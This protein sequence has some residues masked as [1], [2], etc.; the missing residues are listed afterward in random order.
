MK[1]FLGEYFVYHNILRSKYQFNIFFLCF[2]LTFLLFTV[3][4]AKANIEIDPL[5]H[6]WIDDSPTSVSVSGNTGLVGLPFY[7]TVY[8]FEQ[9]ELN[10]WNFTTVL[11]AFQLDESI[12]N[13]RGEFGASVSISNNHIIIGAPFEN[14]AYIFVRDSNNIWIEQDKL[15][16]TDIPLSR[17]GTSVSISGNTALIGTSSEATYVFSRNSDGNWIQETILS[18]SDGTPGDNFGLQVSL[19]GNTALI[20]ANR[21]TGNDTKS[22]AAYVFIRD[23]N[24]DWIQQAKLIGI[25]SEAYDN[26]GHSVSLSDNDVI[27]GATNAHDDEYINIGASY[28]FTRDSNGNWQQQAK[29]FANDP[30]HSEQFGH[31]VS[32]SEDIAIIGDVEAAGRAIGSV[33]VFTRDINDNWIKQGRISTPLPTDYDSLGTKLNF[34]FSVSISNSDN[35]AFAGLNH[36]ATDEN[37][38]AAY[39]INFTRTDKDSDGIYDNFDNCPSLSNSS[40]INNDDD[41]QGDACDNDDDNDGTPDL[42]DI[43]PLND[44]ESVDSDNDG[45]GNNADGDNDNDGIPN[46]IETFYVLDPLNY[47]DALQDLDNDGFS[48]LDEYHAGTNLLDPNDS[49]DTVQHLHYKILANDAQSDYRFGNNIIIEGDR[50]FIAATGGNQSVSY[51]MSGA[52]YS[53]HVSGAVYIYERDPDENWSFQAK[54]TPDDSTNSDA[55]GSSIAVSGNILLI[56]ASGGDGLNPY[57]GAAYAFVRNDDGS[58]T[59]EAKLIAG[60]GNSNDNFGISISLSGNTALIGA[61]RP[62][63]VYVYSRDNNGNWTQQEKLMPN[64]TQNGEGFG[65]SIS[66]S[67]DTALIG[68]YSSSGNQPNS[69]AA[70]IFNLDVNGSW[71]QQ[72]KLIA[73]DGVSNDG[74]GYSVSL[75]GET[76]IIGASSAQGNR[77]NSGAAYIYTRNTAESWQELSKLYPIDGE[78][79]DDFGADVSLFGNLALV[80]APQDEMGTTYVYSNDVNGNW[81][82]QGKL[83]AYK[84]KWKNHFGSSV[85]ISN[86][87]ILSGAPGTNDSGYMSGAVYAL[88]YVTVDSDDDG[89]YDSFDNCPTT[90]NSDQADVDDDLIGDTCDIDNDNDGVADINDRFPTDPLESTDTDNDGI[91]DNKDADAD[92]DG[93]P[94][95]IEL[96]TGLN[97]INNLDAVDDIDND[98]FTNIIEYRT[99]ASLTDPD[100]NPN[101]LQQKQFKIF[102]SDGEPYD[103]FGESVAIENDTV[104]VGAPDKNAAYIF[105]RTDDGNWTQQAKLTSNNKKTRDRFGTSVAINNDV[106][107]VGADNADGTKTDSGAVYVFIRDSNGAWSKQE[108]LTSNNEIEHGHFGNAV[109]ISNGTA[110]I[111]SFGER[112]AYIFTLK[113][114]NTWQLQT[115]LRKA[116]T[117]FGMDVSIKG[118]TAIVSNGEFPI[119]AYIYKRDILG[120]WKEQ[121][122]LTLNKDAGNHTDNSIHLSS[123]DTVLIGAKNNRDLAYSA[124][125]AFIFTRNPDGSWQQQAKLLANDG[126]NYAWFGHSV[127]ISNN[128]ALVGDS[129]TTYVFTR[130]IDDSWLQQGKLKTNGRSLLLGNNISLSGNT[131]IIGTNNDDLGAHAGAAY[132]FEIVDTDSDSDGIYDMF[133]N[134]LSVLNRD[135]QNFDGDNLGDVCDF[136]K[137]NDGIDDLFDR[138]PLDPT[139]S[140]DTDNDSI[141][142]NTDSDDDND[143]LP[144]LIELSSGLN[145]L[146]SSDAT[147]DY[148]NDSFDN[149]DEFLAGTSLTDINDYPDSTQ[150]QHIKI[151]SGE[152]ADYENFGYSISIFGDTALIGAHQTDSN[153]GHSGAAFIYS[154][155]NE[156][157]WIHQAKLTPNDNSDDES[158]GESVLLIDKTAFVGSPNAYVNKINTGAVYVFSQNSEGKWSQQTTITASDSKRYDN[159]GRSLAAHNDT[160]VVGADASNISPGMVYVFNKNMEGDWL[161]QA[162]IMPNDSN[163]NARFGISVAIEDDTILIGASNSSYY[164]YIEYFDYDYYTGSAYVFARDVDGNWS[165]QAK[166][167]TNDSSYNDNF[168][169]SVSLSG[170]TA[171]IGA[172]G[173]ED[174]GYNA[175]AAYIFTRDENQNWSQS[176]KLIANNGQAF[177]Y[178][179]SSVTLSGKIAII[180]ASGSYG[181]SENSGSGYIF[182]LNTDGTWVYRGQLMANDGAS[183]DTFGSSV[184]FIDNHLFVGALGVDD[185]GNDSGAVYAFNFDHDEDGILYLND[186]CPM[187]YNTDQADTDIDG[188]GNACDSDDDNDGVDDSKDRFPLDTTEWIDSDSDGTGDNTDTDDDNDLIPDTIELNYGLNPHNPSDASE[189]IDNDGLSNLKEFQLQTNLASKDTDG[190]GDTDAIELQYG[191]DPLLISDNLDKFRPH[192]PALLAVDTIVPLSLGSLDSEPFSDPDQLEGDYLS[193]TEWE[194]STDKGFSKFNK[195]LHRELN[196]ATNTDDEQFVRQLLLSNGIFVTNTSYWARTRHQDRTGLWSKWSE[197]MMLTTVEA[198]E[199]DLDNNGVLDQHQVIGYIDTNKNGVADNEESINAIYDSNNGY[200][201]GITTSSGNLTQLTSISSDNIPSEIMPI[202]GFPF[203]LFSFRIDGLEIN[204]E[205]PTS[206]DVTFYFPEQLPA[207]ANGTNTM[208]QRI[209]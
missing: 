150:I 5:T 142:D 76:A 121:T 44:R 95:T 23:I 25:D 79:Y 191:T 53:Y 140:I 94:D 196:G 67:G 48:N 195:V 165:E 104:I 110:I 152:G 198:D 69:G 161:E 37:L 39:S 24:G 206:A 58:W 89:Y 73:S 151:L 175:G 178:F 143:G 209:N 93:L 55:F 113:S 132:V 193:A 172:T 107:L 70:Y 19:S 183:D 8:L 100:D 86:N 14:A 45:I 202:N 134:C 138:F 3:N 173:V 170:N 171:L 30:R 28:I 41:Q 153:I 105:I 108:K 46:S 160:L 111:S 78:S 65:K 83:R 51:L 130:N 189:D 184:S 187:A 188:F 122:K 11:K 145:P 26:F 135:Q 114:N 88:N 139:E 186:N 207:S 120:N 131:A 127:T 146:D 22:G 27:I 162:K 74:F 63:V 155:N 137:D 144:D 128:I 174:N 36:N 33:Y 116:S 72:A 125:A 52:V 154:L 87:T 101:I 180:G 159:F 197:S 123:E 177:D 4:T 199:R 84:N 12:S 20:G 71:K 56:G 124:G 61:S 167:K 31:S 32:L 38:P 205:I 9:D 64:N 115:T 66:I 54:L 91:G 204:E 179:G 133:D 62:G 203:G 7:N 35:I 102:A 149:L 81:S 103:H 68:A 1:G 59:Q 57:S 126:K 158:Y 16:V 6:W 82:L 164:E 129:T 15:T 17:F 90:P 42:E 190:D 21:A 141:G 85:A 194:I 43:F 119:S 96:S 181:K 49:Q 112:S 136:D 176:S 192:T 208:H 148:D 169:I 99:G 40:Q 156:G 201:I 163:Y 50:A 34:G 117:S 13:Y 18:A 185:N 109:S 157:R 97:P 60:D 118:N 166:L 92:N 106:A 168:G 29:L 98:G 147:D 200:I 75:F 182:H 80:S 77:I 47:L 10:K 2:V